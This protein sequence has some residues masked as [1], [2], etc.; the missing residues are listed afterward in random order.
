[1]KFKAQLVV[2]GILKY[3][4]TLVL[5]PRLQIYNFLR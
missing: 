1:M 5:R 2:L 3:K 4:Y